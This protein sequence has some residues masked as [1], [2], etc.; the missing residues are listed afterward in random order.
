[1]YNATKHKIKPY[2]RGSL[3]NRLQR[4]IQLQLLI[5]VYRARPGLSIRDSPVTT[6][7]VYK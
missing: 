3:K 7:T 6:S 4:H 1:M 2:C 5:D